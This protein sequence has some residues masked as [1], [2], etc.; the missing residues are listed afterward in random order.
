MILKII[1]LAKRK[2]IHHTI[3]TIAASGINVYELA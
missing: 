1:G 2:Y 3:H